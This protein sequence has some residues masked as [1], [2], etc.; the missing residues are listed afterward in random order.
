MG[1]LKMVPPP[2]HQQQQ[3]EQRFPLPDLSAAPQIKRATDKK[4]WEERRLMTCEAS[5]SFA[6][7]LPERTPEVFIRIKSRVFEN[8]KGEDPV[9]NGFAEKTK[10]RMHYHKK[11][12]AKKLKVCARVSVCCELLV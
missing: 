5:S 1:Q 10:R 3:E 11:P 9:D 12:L 7:P 8:G 2:P 6:S 4:S